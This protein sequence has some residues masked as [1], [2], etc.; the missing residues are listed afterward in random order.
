M[1]EAADARRL[2]GAFERLLRQV[3][4]KVSLAG[5]GHDGITPML[6]AQQMAQPENEPMRRSNRRE[7]REQDLLEFATAVLTAS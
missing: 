7:V 2:P 6:L 1:G 5:E 4:I 3:G